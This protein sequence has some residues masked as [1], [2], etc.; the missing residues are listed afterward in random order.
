MNH[1]AELRPLLSLLSPPPGPAGANGRLTRAAACTFTNTP[2]LHFLLDRHPRHSN[3]VLASAC[4]GHGYK[5]SSVI[6]EVLADLA[7]NPGGA[8]QHDISL[9][10]LSRQRTGQASVLDAFAQG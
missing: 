4:S 6:G 2:D 9:F 8:T 5:F 7:L 1:P 3:V 10:R